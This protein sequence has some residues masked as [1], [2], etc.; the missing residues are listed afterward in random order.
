MFYTRKHES[1]YKKNPVY[2]L[3]E[4]YLNLPV[5]SVMLI[6]YAYP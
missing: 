5:S 6:H 2:I 3:V 1:V 4:R